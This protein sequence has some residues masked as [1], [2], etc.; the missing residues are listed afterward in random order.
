MMRN[1]VLLTA[2]SLGCFS[3]VFAQPQK[4]SADKI[5]AVVGNK[6]VLKSDIDNSIT[7]MQRQGMEIPANARCMVL[8]QALNVKALVLQ[9]EKDSLPVTDE[10]VEIEIDNQIR[11]FIGAYGS[12]DELEKVAGRS[13]Y[14]LK[15][16]FREGFRDRKLSSAMRDKIVGDIRIT[17]NEVNSYFQRIAKDSLPYYESEVEIGQIVSYPKAS[18]DAEEYAIEQLNE[19]K[20]AIESGKKDFKTLA[21]LY[22]EDPGSKDQGGMFEFNRTQKN[23]DPTFVSKAFTLKEGQ[24]TNPFKSK[25]GYHIIQMV[26]RA[27]DDIVVRHIL[28]I[29][30]VTN[31]E[32]KGS[33]EKL[34]SVRSKLIAGTIDFGAAVSRYSEDEASKF[35]AGMIQGPNGSFLTIDQLDKD[36]IPLLKTLTVGAYSQPVEYND[37][38]GKKALRIIYLKSQSAPHRENM[39]DDYSKIAARAL[40]E[41]KEN[42]LE[43]WFLKKIKT[44]YV[45]VDPEYQ[46]CESMQ[47]WVEAAS[48]KK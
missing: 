41:K 25:F 12:K 23:V 21:A 38:R 20:T 5:V 7:D 22:S 28:K 44:Y 11:N 15:E 45:M 8:E 2:L 37:E 13:V 39:K 34:D 18:R 36:M 33:L 40:E 17:P 4:V 35:T 26:S 1:K 16:D 31:I 46:S 3:A 10:E 9:A 43:T 30:Q 47:K 42:A 6:I 27:G 32:T 19:Y 48:A 29:P 14:Q 24:I